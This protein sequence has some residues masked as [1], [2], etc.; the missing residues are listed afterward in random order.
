[1]SATTIKTL[2]TAFA[3]LDGEA[4]QQKAGRGRDHDSEQRR[5]REAELLCG[6]LRQGCH[7]A[8]ES[9]LASAV[10]GLSFSAC[11]C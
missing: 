6:D 11:S 9:S 5:E 10:Q 1:M 4:M 8:N 3:R 7:A 2:Y